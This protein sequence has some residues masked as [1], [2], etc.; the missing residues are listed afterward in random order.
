MRKTESSLT[1][2]TDKASYGQG[3]AVK[4]RLLNKNTKPI[5]VIPTLFDSLPFLGTLYEKNGTEFRSVTT[6]NVRASV[7][8][9]AERIPPEAIQVKAG[10]VL[11]GVWNGYAFQQIGP[12]EW[13]DW[14]LFQPSGTFKIRIF[15]DL[16]SGKNLEQG[17]SEFWAETGEFKIKAR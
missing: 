10:E 4:L 12:D 2:T 6:Q 9:K 7:I 1:A 11:E 3:E 16:S 5:F 8:D 14:E 15:Y 13:N 17:K